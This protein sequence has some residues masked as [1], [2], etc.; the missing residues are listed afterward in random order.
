MTVT[1][2]WQT[3]ITAGAFLAAVVGITAKIA[4][5]VR[6]V[7]RQ[8]EQDTDL[9]ALEAK[10]NADVDKLRAE[11][12]AAI[13]SIQEEQTLLTYGILA[14]LQGLQELGCNGEVTK[15]IKKIDK[16]LNQKAHGG[17]EAS[18]D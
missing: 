4:K 8:E 16:Y 2:T 7:D 14:S 10:H 18:Y 5:A 11:E 13:A 6:W 9:K 3:V 15:A 1:I 12:K 17:T